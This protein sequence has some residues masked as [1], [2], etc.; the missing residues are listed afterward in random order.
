MTLDEYQQKAMETAIYPRENG[1]AYTVLGLAGET[2]EIAEKVKKTIRD[3]QGMFDEAVKLDIAREAGDV[4]WYLAALA[5]ELG[6]TLDDIAC[7][8]LDKLRSRSLRDTLR[9]NGD[10]R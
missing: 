6:M 2:G 5:R 1:I 7:I 4:L 3:R 8:N 9:G 10:N